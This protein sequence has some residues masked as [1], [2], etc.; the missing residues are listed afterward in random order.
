MER[1]FELEYREMK[2]NETPDLWSRIEAGLSDKKIATTT[3]EEPV[4]VRPE[5][6]VVRKQ[7]SWKRWG[8]L[9][10]A[11]LCVVILFP[12]VI[13]GITGSYK[14]SSSAADTSL[15]DEGNMS[16]SMSTSTTAAA[17]ASEPVEESASAAAEEPVGEA[18]S[19]AAEEPVGETDSASETSEA[20]EEAASTLPELTDGQVL[21]GA[22]VQILQ[23][24]ETGEET[25][26]HAVVIEADADAVMED[27]MQ[28]E[29]ICN[30]KT[31]YDFVRA[32]RE[33][34]GLAKEENY[35][36]SLQYEQD[37]LVVLTAAKK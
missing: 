1:D 4:T 36:V 7:A 35:E 37:R 3:L 26:Y 6:F 34:K 9:A 12:A 25:V 13:M 27:G 24:D 18:D 32:P 29:L 14:N 16:G 5:R 8:L 28:V 19:G 31:Q 10:A 15:A 11:C 17:E 22:V 21:E 30:D 33:E 2:Q 20:P 23:V